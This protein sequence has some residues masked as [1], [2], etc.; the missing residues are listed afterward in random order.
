MRN[1]ISVFKLIV[2]IIL[3]RGLINILWFLKVLDVN[4]STNRGMH[5]YCS[6]VSPFLQTVTT[7]GVFLGFL[8]HGE[9]ETYRTTSCGITLTTFCSRLAIGVF[10]DQLTLRLGALGL[11]TF[12]VTFWLLAYCFA[13]G[14]GHLAVSHTMGFFTNI[15]T[16]RTVVAFTGP[17][18]A[19]YLALGFFAFYVTYGIFWLLT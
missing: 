13:L 8:E 16:F 2:I 14:L 11:L 10:T 19:H 12:P 17:L 4:L 1:I 6:P 3:K 5:T 18:G 9:R 15:D 7:T